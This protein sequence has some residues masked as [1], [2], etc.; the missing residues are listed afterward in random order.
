MLTYIKI[1]TCDTAATVETIST[2]TSIKKECEALIHYIQIINSF[3]KSFPTTLTDDKKI[4]STNFREHLA[5]MYRIEMKT[6][7]TNQITL[8]MIAHNILQRINCGMTFEVSCQIVG[9]LEQDS[10]KAII[11]C[12]H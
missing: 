1:I 5:L 11:R 10:G 8:A 12:A 3:L 6:I 9:D 7:A 4:K 2:M